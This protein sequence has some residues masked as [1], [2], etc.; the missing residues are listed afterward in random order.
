MPRREGEEALFE[1]F[2]REVLFRKQ[3]YD[4]IVFRHAH[5]PKR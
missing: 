3:F 2:Y 5:V 1:M 4:D